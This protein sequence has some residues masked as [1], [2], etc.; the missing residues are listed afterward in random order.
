MS[1]PTITPG[2]SPAD[3]PPGDEA[4]AARYVRQIFARV[5]PRYDLLNH[6]LSFQIDRYWR[7][8][9][10]EKASEALVLPTARALDLCCGTGDL[11]LALGRVHSG[12]MF[13]ADFC[14][15]MLVAA[16][17]KLGGHARLIEADALALPVASGSLDLVTIA[18][19]LR[20]LANYR[21]GLQEMRRVLRDG[22]RLAVLEFSQPRGRLLGPMYKLY[23]RYVLPRL[24]GAISGAANAY[25]YLQQ[26]VDKFLSP[27]E[28][29]AA[30]LAVGFRQVRYWPLTGGIAVLHVATK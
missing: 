29:S 5:A 23:F 6:L 12:P 4:T 20:N 25:R 30:M 10:A 27:E 14:R 22:G 26:S 7:R 16:A 3:V 13:G 8:F 9:T 15:P 18:F 17:A 21:N 11:L 24:G 2:T 19:G 1:L 28:L